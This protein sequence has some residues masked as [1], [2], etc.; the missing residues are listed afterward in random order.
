MLN[1]VDL[2]GSE[3]LKKS[4]SEGQRKIEALH[5]NSSLTALGKVRC[6]YDNKNH[7]PDRLLASLSRRIFCRRPMCMAAITASFQLP[8]ATT[9]RLTTTVTTK[10]EGG[11]G[12]GSQLRVDTCPLPRLEADPPTAELP[13][14]QQLYCGARDGAPYCP[15]RWLKAVLVSTCALTKMYDNNCSR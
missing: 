4:A 14:W 9:S 11:N 15:V 5:I 8:R 2:A 3:R 12:V 1:L 6:L 13:G 10:L 7:F